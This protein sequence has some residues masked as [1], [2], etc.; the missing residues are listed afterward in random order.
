MRKKIIYNKLPDYTEYKKRVTSFKI[1]TYSL[2]LSFLIG[3]ITNL[4]KV[5]NIYTLI[6]IK[7]SMILVPVLFII[8]VINIILMKKCPLCNKKFKKGYFQNNDNENNFLFYCEDCKIFMNTF[9]NKSG[10]I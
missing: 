5:K 4:I 1:I 9:F 6:I 8:A 2:F 7:L 10:F 3:L